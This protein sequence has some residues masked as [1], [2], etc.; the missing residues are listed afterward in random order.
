MVKQ[1]INLNFLDK[2]INFLSPNVGLE[3]MRARTVM[4]MVDEYTGA[5]RSQR[6]LFGFMPRSEG[7]DDVTD[8]L[9]RETLLERSRWLVRNNAIASGTIESNCIYMVG[10]GLKL[11]SRIDAKF[12]G[13]TNEEADALETEIEKEFSIFADTPECDIERTLNFYEKQNQTLG[14]VFE[15]GESITFLPYLKRGNN[16]YGLKIQTIEPERL[17]NESNVIDTKKL[18]QGIEKDEYGAP[19]KYHICSVYPDSRMIQDK[20]WDKIDAYKSNNLKNILHHYIPRRPGQTRGIPYITPIIE[21]L[22][23]IGNLRKAE[24]D[25]TV[26]QSLF[27]VFIETETGRGLKPMAPTETGA[28]KTDKDVKLAP[29]AMIDL[30]PGEKVAFAKPERPNPS[31]DAYLHSL[32]QECGIGMFLPAQI[33]MK[34]YNTSYTSARAAFLDAWKFYLMRRIFLVRSFCNPIYENFIFESVA[35]GRLKLPGFLKD[36]RYRR[37]YLNCEWIGPSQGQINPVDEM[38]AAQMADDYGYRTSE[39][40]TEEVFGGSYN[41]NIEQKKREIQ[42]RKDA[43]I[44]NSQKPINITKINLGQGQQ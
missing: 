8:K 4:A 15:A 36:I 37:A 26:V 42:M 18:V 12:L 39:Q 13:L 23:N 22:Y 9:T 28:K 5:S 41:D 40:I 20:K 1:K 14:Q 29:G 11:R 30:K 31:F 35:L 17:S 32:Y 7:P 33:L 6:S 24:L 43:G 2:A 25:A 44:I 3:R 19:V 16:P 38:T 21:L 10:P 34:N 27:S